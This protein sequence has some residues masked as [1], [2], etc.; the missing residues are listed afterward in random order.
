M[1][2]WWGEGEV[3]WWSLRLYKR[4]V[5]S[6]IHVEFYNYKIQYSCFIE[7]KRICIKKSWINSMQLIRKYA[8]WSYTCIHHWVGCTE[9]Q[10]KMI[11]GSGRW[12]FFLQSKSFSAIA[13]HY[14]RE[15]LFR[16]TKISVDIVLQK[17]DKQA[18]YSLTVD[19]KS[20]SLYVG[21]GLFIQATFSFFPH[22]ASLAVPWE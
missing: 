3:L 10:S 18:G 5:I 1:W 9:R 17:M 13:R 14:E 21:K 2:H 12:F 4:P 22:L 8:V 16:T 20:K 6:F 19:E 7:S 15:R 11:S